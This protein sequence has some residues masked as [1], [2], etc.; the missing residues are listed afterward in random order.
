MLQLLE[1]NFEEFK[2]RLQKLRPIF[3][4]YEARLNSGQKI[5]IISHSCVLRTITSQEFNVKGKGISPIKFE[6]AQA[7]VIDQRLLFRWLAKI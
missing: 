1:E 6:N 4:E 5:M 3:A 7:Q 2:L